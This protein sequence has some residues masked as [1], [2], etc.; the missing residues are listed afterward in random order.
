VRIDR[1]EAWEVV[2][3]FRFTFGHALAARASSSNL[4]VAAY[5]ADGSV[6]YGEGVPREYV[7][8]ETPDSVLAR[9]RDQYGPKLIGRDLEATSVLGA[10]TSLRDEVHHNQTPPGASWCAIECALVDALGKAQGRSATDFF[11][12]VARQ[13]VRYSGVAPFGDSTALAA[14]LLFFRAYGFRDIKLKVGRD[15]ERDIAA[16]RL[17]R[18]IMGPNCDLRVDANCAW[19]ADETL[20]MAERLRP[21]G[22]RSY[23]QPVPADDVRG[24]KRLTAE[25]SEPIIVDESLWSLEHARRLA[26]E[27]ACSGFNIRVSKCGGPI[28]ALEIVE[29]ARGAGLTCQLGAQ[30]G[31]SG[32]LTAAGRLVATA[33]RFPAFKYLEGSH[34]FFL[35][36]RDLTRENLTVG[37][38]G[39]ASA[40]S[41]V[42]FGVQVRRDRLAQMASRR[43]TIGSGRSGLSTAAELLQ[44]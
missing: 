29:V 3:P 30:V 8:G 20:R 15:R 40:L 19:D 32:I 4:I 38:G 24:L 16:V 42:G 21:F 31:E 1:L 9:V 35:L 18:R 14:M 17:A 22:V 26:A 36:K 33:A 23:E 11:G 44:A 43:I 37:P 41:G 2:L 25:L 6:G 39:R 34:N 12:G 27:Y 7:T 13:T 28:G 10:L 5:L